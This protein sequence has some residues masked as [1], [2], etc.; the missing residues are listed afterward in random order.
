MSNGYDYSRDQ[1]LDVFVRMRFPERSDRESTLY[2]DFLQAHIHE[3]ENYSFQVRV[4]QGVTPNPDHL[5]G[6]QRQTVRNSKMKIDMLA[7]QGPQ[8]FIFEVKERAIHAAIGQLITYRHLWME[9]NP[10][11]REPRL[12]VIART[13]EPD[14]EPV[15]AANGID[16]YLYPPAAG[17]GRTPGGGLSPVDGA[18]A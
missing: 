2:R 8:P 13:I 17:D 5:P 14:M 6:V 3:Y 4:G 9:E 7:W 11:A 16:V 1:L 10:D 15:F 12:A 18:T